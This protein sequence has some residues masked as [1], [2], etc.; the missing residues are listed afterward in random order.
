MS[1]CFLGLIVLGVTLAWFLVPMPQ[2]QAAAKSEKNVYYWGNKERMVVAGGGEQNRTIVSLDRIPRHMQEAVISAENA[3]F[4]DDS[5]VDPMGIARAAFNMAF[6]D[7]ETQSGSTITQQYVKNTMLSQEQTLKRKAVELLT[8]VKVGAKTNK[9][10]IL[11]DYLNSAYFGRGAYGIQAASQAYFGKDCQDLQPDE[12][13]FLATLLNGPEYYDPAGGYNSSPAANLKRAESR[14]KWILDREVAVAGQAKVV[15]LTPAQRAKY[16]DFPRVKQPSK[17]TELKG[18][19]GYL[20]DL[21]NNYLIS[22][23]DG[24]ITRKSLQEGGY[25]IHT[26]FDKKKTYALRD[27]VEKVRKRSIKPKERDR[28]RYV[29]FGGASVN[30]ADGAIRAI[31]GGEDATKHYT[32]NSDYT[33]AQVGSTFKPFVLAAAMRD[34]VRDPS[35]PPKQTMSTRKRVS[36]DSVYNGD[37]KVTL[38]DYN[39]KTWLGKGDK[40]WK[41][42]NDGD[43]NRGPVSLRNAMEQSTNTPFIQLGMD[44]GLDKVRKAA[45]DAGVNESSLASLTP[46]FSLGTSAPSAIRMASSYGTFAKSGTHAE[47][48][49]VKYAEKR[50]NRIYEHKR[51]TRQAFAPEVADNVTDVLQGVI[52]RG[53]GTTAKALGRPAAGKTGTTD[54]N[55]SAWFTGYTPQLSTAIGMWRVDDQAKK[56]KFLTM[57]GVGGQQKVHGAS[58]PAE[59]WTSYMSKA[60]NG[61]DIEQFPKAPPIGEKVNGPGASTS[62]P[63]TKSEDPTPTKSEP[64][65]PSPSETKPSDSASPSSPWGGNQNGGNQDGGQNGGADGGNPNG[66]NQDGGQNGGEDWGGIFGGPSNTVRPRD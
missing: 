61:T 11:R 28:D 39:N 49:S 53:T 35:L 42:R 40:I 17:T 15:G 66:G 58:F 54:D 21:A 3:T 46:T 1:I 25:E 23:S 37:N 62:P 12:S 41:Q 47:P 7:G 63:P 18:Q 19:I 2:V 29:Q 9:K 8:S 64:S 56:Q 4:Y 52:K 30:P 14:W 34:G 59:I 13:A 20:V 65:S 57:Y 31:Y 24:K 36:P 51:S 22:N 5:G 6:R 60:L 27:S 33:G 55:K 26:T 16:K 48:F 50:G 43:E 32:N 44:V 38:R 10:I 45:L